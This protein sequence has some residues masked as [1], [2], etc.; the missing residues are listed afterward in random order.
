K[1]IHLFNG[2]FSILLLTQLF[3]ENRDVPTSGTSRCLIQAVTTC[4]RTLCTNIS[5]STCWPNGQTTFANVVQPTLV[6]AANGH[7][8]HSIDWTI[9]NTIGFQVNAGLELR[10][11]RGVLKACKIHQGM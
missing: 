4:F 6:E 2:F 7:Q 3:T 1:P 10:T 11:I 8:S 5:Q 9:G